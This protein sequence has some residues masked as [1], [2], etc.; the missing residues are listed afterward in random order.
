M[1]LQE[2]LNVLADSALEKDTAVVL[3]ALYGFHHGYLR[4]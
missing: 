1:L 3:A 4:V 2:T